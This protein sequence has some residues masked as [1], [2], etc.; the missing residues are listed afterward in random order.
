MHCS[1]RTIWT[2][3]LALVLVLCA[4]IHVRPVWADPGGSMGGG[5]PSGGT[6]GGESGGDPDDPQGGGGKR[7]SSSGPSSVSG[8]TLGEMR[9]T[10][11]VS[12]NAARVRAEMLRHWILLAIRARGL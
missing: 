11:P 1:R 9:Y 4:P 12:F 10:A 8:S 6:S 2:L 5:D 3:V 7:G